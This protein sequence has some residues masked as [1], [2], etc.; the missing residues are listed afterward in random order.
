MIDDIKIRVANRNDIEGMVELQKQIY[1]EYK[2]DAPFFLWQ[3]F[4]NVNPSTLIVA[5]QGRSI[6]GTFGIQKRKTTGGLYGGQLS[7]L[8]IAEDKRRSG[9]FERMGNFALK[10][11]SD[12]DF[13]I[14]F[15]NKNAVLPCKKA[16]DMKFIGNIC[17]LILK[18]ISSDVHTESQVEQIN[19]E[20]IFH[21]FPCC[22][23]TITFLRTEC[24][25]RWR[26]AKN[27]VYKYFKVSIPT[28]EYAIIKL[29]NE[30][31]S[32]QQTIGDIV[33]FECDIGD[34]GKLWYLFHTVFFELKKI[35]ATIITTWAVP[36]SALR[37]LLD[38]MG[39]TE[40][41]HCSFLGIKI[42]NKKYN[43]P[44]NFNNWHFVQ[45]DASNY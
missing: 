42:L 31:K 29:F 9:L 37:C 32:K 18:N 21:N 44:Y 7:W 35:G 2:R 23:N 5:Q 25:R 8:V 19:N 20:T 34:V 13:I 6:V 17:Q 45:S 36:G 28:G 26:Y 11:I 3:C 27:T 40:S 10:C 4:E 39:F 30:R 41:E 43:Q 38:E 33:D 24:Y 1:Y 15:A 16:F 14:V 22:I 12:L